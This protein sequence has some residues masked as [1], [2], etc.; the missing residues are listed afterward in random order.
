MARYPVPGQ[1]KTRLAHAIG[2]ENACV[3]YRAFLDDIAARF[4][5]GSRALVWVF[6]PPDAEFSSLVAPCARCIPQRGRDLSERL[7]NCF[8]VLCGE[9]FAHVI[10]IGADAPHLRDE[11][12]DEAEDALGHADVV[13][14]PSADGGYYLIAMRAPHDV[15]TGIEL[16]TE[17]VLSETVAKAEG[18]ALRVHLLPPSFDVDGEDDLERLR[19]LLIREGGSQR[20]PHTA[21]VLGAVGPLAAA[22]R[23]KRVRTRE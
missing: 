2:A 23:R 16:S 7:Y 13:L 10:V 18:A 4:A 12:L 5:G 11:W 20:L 1:V 21:R 6:H 8:R 15:F 19:A 3:L 14:G 9:G 17:R 22:T